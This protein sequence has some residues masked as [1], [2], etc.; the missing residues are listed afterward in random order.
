MARRHLPPRERQK[1][2][3]QLR[4]K[5]KQEAQQRL[6]AE[7]SQHEQRAEA[8]RQFAQQARSAAP[9]PAP[10]QRRRLP[11]WMKRLYM[12]IGVIF[13][14]ELGFATL[15]APQM[16]IKAVSITGAE[17]TP[18]NVLRPIAQKLLGQNLLRANR[19]AVEKAVE[20]LPTVAYAHVA[21]LPVWPPKAQLQITERQPVLKVGSG[22]DWWVVDANG[23]PFRRAAPEDDK[24]YQVVAPNFTPEQGKK[25]DAKAWMRADRL[26]EA[27]LADNQIAASAKSDS[28][29]STADTDKAPFWQLRRIYFDKS[30][31]ASLRV[32]GKGEL[33]AHNEMLIRL[34]DE[35]WTEKLARAR[36]ALGYFER[37]G[38]HATELDLVSL[39][40]PVWRSV[41]AQIATD[42]DEKAP[43]QQA[44]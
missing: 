43:S 15:T 11:V 1:R 6:A 29:N 8:E 31:L 21:R 7:S 12:L 40:Y 30:G 39:D 25:L 26:N 13:V 17:S 41:P 27:I 35:G 34:G 24:L 5:E 4:Q 32:T 36:V 38:R 23:I 37:T 28:Q 22:N 44:G 16:N 10:K 2:E 9:R 42:G 14:G 33:T 19:K 20:A 18:E 3:R